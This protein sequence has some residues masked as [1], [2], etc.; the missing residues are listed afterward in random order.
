MVGQ[1]GEV[2]ETLSNQVKK[3]DKDL[4]SKNRNYLRNYEST[5]SFSKQGS[6][7]VSKVPRGI[8]KIPNEGILKNKKNQDIH[9]AV[10]GT[11]SKGK[12]PLNHTSVDPTM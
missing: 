3:G 8:L 2:N 4:T 7:F 12:S 11:I 6:K 5:Y 9:H 10:S 1:I